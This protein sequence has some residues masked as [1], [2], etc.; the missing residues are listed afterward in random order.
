MIAFEDLASKK[1]KLR[2]GDKEQI[3]CIK[4]EANFQKEEKEALSLFKVI[5]HYSGEAEMEVE[6]LD[7]FDAREKAQEE[8]H[9]LDIEWTGVE[10]IEVELIKES[11]A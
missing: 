10:H 5:V 2:F 4:R 6:A 8:S 9:D 7:E 11:V 3:E 1:V